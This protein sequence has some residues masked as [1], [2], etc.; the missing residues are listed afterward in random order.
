MED[1]RYAA[2][3]VL[4]GTHTRGLRPR[5][6]TAAAA[7]RLAQLWGWPWTSHEGDRYRAAPHRDWTTT[8]A[9]RFRSAPMFRTV[10]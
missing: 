7:T 6:H 8:R 9:R 4:C 1:R 10:T 5:A 2:T 3:Y